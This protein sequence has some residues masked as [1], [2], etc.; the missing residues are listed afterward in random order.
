MR[1]FFELIHT[2]SDESIGIAILILSII[3]YVCDTIRDIYKNK[4]R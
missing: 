4:K 1:E 2:Y 3:W